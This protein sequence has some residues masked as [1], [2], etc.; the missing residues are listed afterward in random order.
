[1]SDAGTPVL[2]DFRR[3]RQLPDDRRSLLSAWREAVAFSLVERW[4]RQLS[5]QV[6]WQPAEFEMLRRADLIDT[7]GPETLAYA[8]GL[9]AD[10]ASMWLLLPRPFVLGILSLMLGDAITELPADRSPTDLETSLIEL[11]V[12]EFVGAMQ[13][14]QS[15][16]IPL[17]CRLLGDRRAADAKKDY[18]EQEP[19]ACVRWTANA[20]FGSGDVRWCLSQAAVHSYIESLSDGKSAE[21]SDRSG[22]LIETLRQVPLEVVVHLGSTEVHVSELLNLQPGDVVVLDQRVNEP[23][24]AAIAGAP[25]F[26]GWPGKIGSRQALKIS[27][28]VS[29]KENE[30]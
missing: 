1:M 21:H 20:S 18:A 7:V 10:S 6:S 29:T 27:G 3:P 4:N 26:L 9:G 11:A 28:M 14:A 13:D 12:Q 19:I 16:I 23:L 5:V 2:Y 15:A 22:I 8:I 30:T 24:T 25:K 17:T